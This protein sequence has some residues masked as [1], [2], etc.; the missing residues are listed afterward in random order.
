MTTNP[1]ESVH[2][3]LAGLVFMDRTLDLRREV[4]VHGSEEL[5]LRPRTFGVLSHLLM[6]AGRIVTKQELME[7]VWA[8]AAVTDDSLVQCLIEIRRAS[9]NGAGRRENRSRP[10]VPGGL[11]RAPRPA[12]P[13]DASRRRA[14]CKEASCK[15][16]RRTTVSTSSPAPRECRDAMAHGGHRPRRLRIPHLAVV[17]AVGWIRIGPATTA[18]AGTRTACVYGSFHNRSAAR[19]RPG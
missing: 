7:T 11:R 16:L 1:P 13:G 4:L 15:T 2:P 17:G 5:R 18:G 19:T 12:A 3:A 9:G 8:D 14:R 10:R 6:N